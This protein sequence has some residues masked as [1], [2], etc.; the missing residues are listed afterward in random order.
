M[1]TKVELIK[2]LKGKIVVY[3]ILNRESYWLSI[4]KWDSAIDFWWLLFLNLGR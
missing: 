2:T 3:K 4:A 1:A